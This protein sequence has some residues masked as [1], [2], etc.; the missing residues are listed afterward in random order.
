MLQHDLNVD[1]RDSRVNAGADPHHGETT[2][3]ECV[4]FVTD[5]LGERLGIGAVNPGQQNDEFLASETCC[6]IDVSTFVGE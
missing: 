2:A 5:T 4:E 6:D 1:G 3:A